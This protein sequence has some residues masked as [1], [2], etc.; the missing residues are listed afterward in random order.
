MCERVCACVSERERECVGFV[1][2]LSELV[3]K[4]LIDPRVHL[5][6]RGAE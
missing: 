2:H 3:Q 5:Q 4:E 6:S 1:V